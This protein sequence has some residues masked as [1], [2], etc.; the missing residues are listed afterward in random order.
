MQRL[1]SSVIAF[2]F[3]A[4]LGGGAAS[5]KSCRDASGKFMKCPKTMATPA[6]TK[7]RDAKGKFMKCKSKM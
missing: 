4:A 1:A 3:V 5:A 7:C 6:P 2:L